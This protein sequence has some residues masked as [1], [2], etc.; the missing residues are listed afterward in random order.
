MKTHGEVVAE[1]KALREELAAERVA[2]LS[3]P[4]AA[5][6]LELLALFQAHRNLR[7]DYER[8]RERVA[9]LEEAK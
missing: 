8:L 9:A 4:N 1:L 6:S 5:S 2:R 7:E 3:A